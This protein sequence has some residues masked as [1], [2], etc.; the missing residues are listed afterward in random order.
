MFKKYNSGIGKIAKF[1]FKFGVLGDFMLTIIAILYMFWP[2]YVSIKFYYDSWPAI[3]SGVTFS[4]IF[5]I[6]G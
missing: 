6:S 2:C 4:I 1:L 5:M 3:I